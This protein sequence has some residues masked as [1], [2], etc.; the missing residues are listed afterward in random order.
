MRVVLR[1]LWF[2]FRFFL[3]F[4]K[5]CCHKVGRGGGAGRRGGGGGEGEGRI[6]FP[7]ASLGHLQGCQDKIVG[8]KT[9]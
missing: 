3:C 2:Y 7:Y 9:P 5:R 1:N 8:I 4:Y 6:L